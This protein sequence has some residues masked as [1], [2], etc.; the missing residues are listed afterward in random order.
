[1]VWQWVLLYHQQYGVVV[2]AMVVVLAIDVD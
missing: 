1:V 2:V